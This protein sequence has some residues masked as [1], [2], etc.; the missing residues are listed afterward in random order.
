MPLLTLQIQ[1]ILLHI[2]PTQYS[3]K[4]IIDESVKCYI[5]LNGIP[6]GH[7]DRIVLGMSLL[8][9]FHLV[10]DDYASKVGFVARSG[11]SSITEA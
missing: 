6:P 7:P 8:H 9:S 10:F 4:V 1:G 11:K 3:A 2:E 5:L